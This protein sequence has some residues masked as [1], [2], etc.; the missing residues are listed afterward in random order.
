MYSC[1]AVV[2]RSNK[3]HKAAVVLCS[4]NRFPK[5]SSSCC[6]CCCCCCVLLPILQITVRLTNAENQLRLR[7]GRE[8][9]FGS[10]RN[11][12]GGERQRERKSR[13]TAEKTKRNGIEC[14]RSYRVFSVPTFAKSNSREAFGPMFSLV[15]GNNV[16]KPKTFFLRQPKN[17]FF[18]VVQTTARIHRP[19]IRAASEENACEFI[20][21]L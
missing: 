9:N 4:A 3:T 15:F 17:P 18:V 2:V 16:G 1:A 19:Q 8:K 12:H 11:G 13:R 7:G 5:A 21:R 20:E 6:C 10:G 14:T